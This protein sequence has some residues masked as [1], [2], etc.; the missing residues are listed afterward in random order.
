M[1]LQRWLQFH[2]AALAVLG[3]WFLI[4]TGDRSPFPYALAISALVA[5]FVTDHKHWVTV[6]RTLGNIGALIAVSWSM[7]NFMRQAREDQLLTISHMLIYL[8]IVL[9]FQGK[10]R[11]VYWQLLV[12]SVLQVVVAAALSL[13]P[14]FGLLLILY[15]GNAI[16]CMLLLC[17]QRE[18]GH[19]SEAAPATAKSPLSL[20]RLLDPPKLLP[21]SR[22]QQ[23]EHW[24]NGPWLLR[25]VLMFTAASIIFTLVFFFSAPRMSEAMW[26]TARGRGGVSG[27]SGEV[28]LRTR[29]QISLSD[30]PVMRVSL[31]REDNREP[32]PLV[33]EPYFHGQV[34]THYG[35]DS[36]GHR[37]TWTAEFPQGP[38]RNRFRPPRVE[39]DNPS[40]VVRQDIVLEATNSPVLFALMPVLFLPD[41]PASVREFRQSP[42]LIRLAQEEQ[43]NASREFRFA[44][45]TIG[46]RNGRQL[47]AIPHYHPTSTP[48]QELFLESEAAYQRDREHL[49][50][51]SPDRFPG[52]K[53]IADQLIEEH[54]LQQASALERAIALQ[55]YLFV[56]GNFAYSLDLND[57]QHT[58]GDRLGIDPLEDFVVYRRKGHCE[59]FASAL[60]MMLRSQ[61]IPARMVIGY[62]GGD[63][64]TLG[65]YYLVRQKHAHAWVEVLL[66]PHEVPADQV[67][68][69][70]HGGG[71]WYRLDPTPGSV[72]Q[73]EG[74]D[75]SSVFTPISD[76]FD[77][78]DYL[79]RDYVLGLNAGRQ[80]SVMDP[81]TARSR[82]IFPPSL[83][84]QQMTKWAQGFLGGEA[85]VGDSEGAKNSPQE[86]A[87]SSLWGRFALFALLV[88]VSPAL[89]A[90]GLLLVRYWSQKLFHRRRSQAKVS[91]SFAAIEQLLAR[92][93]IKV[94]PQA[95]ATELLA[96]AAERLPG[97]A[98][99][100]NGHPTHSL[101][102]MLQTV[103][104]EYHRVR[105]GSPTDPTAQ[106]S[107]QLAIANLQV[108]LAQHPASFAPPTTSG[109]LSSGN[110]PRNTD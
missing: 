74:E 64:N 110:S 81:I 85:A 20:H 69:K 17:Y 62:K 76:A 26:Q 46:V 89:L 84:P 3:G 35:L 95:T 87:E 57:P 77:Y 22:Q 60:V 91:P 44:I 9:V 37:H 100:T 63:W 25:S 52:L 61:N 43:V 72:E 55:N 109:N 40:E 11:R 14:Q 1:S 98:K 34:L 5:L 18:L 103:I 93:G 108:A 2:T 53:K 7:R 13:G 19:E 70:L 80:E 106:R 32:V 29:G 66:E 8:Q 39:H 73:V 51:F 30:Q 101:L 82:D 48:G 54:K 75:R 38:R 10:S 49:R 42:R 28:E 88:V 41:T 99:T 31:S 104:D 86:K 92:R 105:F 97:E 67:A 6:P 59:Y 102:G 107:L 96:L 23:L 27:F 58:E 83:D 45:G 16:A 79:W 15:M 56:S 12:L 65:E 24:I 4:L 36:T 50:E 47:R 21:S 71:A 94:Q 78:A 90:A 68:G 33:T